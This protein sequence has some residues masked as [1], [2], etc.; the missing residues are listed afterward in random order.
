MYILKTS[1]CNE[2][3]NYTYPQTLSMGLDYDWDAETSISKIELNEALV[4]EP[5]FDSFNLD[6][7]TKLTDIVSQ[8]FIYAN[9]LLVSPEFLTTIANYSIQPHTLFPAKVVLH[10]KV[11]NYSWMHMIDETESHI[12][13]NKSRFERVEK[14]QGIREEIQIDDKV[15]LRN[16]CKEFTTT[17]G[18]DLLAKELSFYESSCIHDLFFLRLTERTVFVS[19]RLGSILKQDLLRGFEVILTDTKVG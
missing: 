14:A 2:Q 10:H 19:D 13:F 18:I 15:Q 5:D 6:P 9:G 8:G 17:M 12:D 4:V 11:S 16:L 3:N 1:I 7:D